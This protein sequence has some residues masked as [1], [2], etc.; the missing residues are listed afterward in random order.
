MNKGRQFDDVV[1][2]QTAKRIVNGLQIHISQLEE[3]DRTDRRAR[4]CYTG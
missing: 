1:N 4:E 3:R 2:K